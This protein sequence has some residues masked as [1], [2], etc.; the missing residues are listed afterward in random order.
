MLV[1]HCNITSQSGKRGYRPIGTVSGFTGTPMAGFVMSKFGM[2]HAI[3]GRGRLYSDICR[4][5][6]GN[7]FVC[8]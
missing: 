5:T 4:G 1:G 2:S 7:G 8:F 6:C 3:L